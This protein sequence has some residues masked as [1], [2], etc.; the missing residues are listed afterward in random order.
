MEDKKFTIKESFLGFVAMNSSTAENVAETAV[1]KL[2][3]LGIK[4]ERLLAQVNI[5]IVNIY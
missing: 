1:K 4:I 5:D 3:D 2:R